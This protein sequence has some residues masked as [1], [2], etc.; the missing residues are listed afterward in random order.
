MH[1]SF[2]FVR[3]GVDML[4]IWKGERED[5]NK[6]ISMANE[7]EKIVHFKKINKNNE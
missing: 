3:M 4:M 6:D 1:S 7:I 5:D 2:A